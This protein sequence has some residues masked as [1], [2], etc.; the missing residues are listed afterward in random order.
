MASL[1]VIHV[2]KCHIF[3][4]CLAQGTAKFSKF[5][6]NIL[7]PGSHRDCM[8]SHLLEIYNFE[9]YN[10]PS[11]LRHGLFFSKFSQFSPFE[12]RSY[13]KYFI[14]LKQRGKI[15]NWTCLKVAHM[16]YFYLLFTSTLICVLLLFDHACLHHLLFCWYKAL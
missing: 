10:I 13:N 4:R 14:P 9:Y 15:S 7:M 5:H 3:E 11:F 2:P 12:L 8:P 6:E 16:A 1:F